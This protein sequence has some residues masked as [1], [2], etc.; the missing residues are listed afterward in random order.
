MNVRHVSRSYFDALSNGTK[1]VAA[2]CRQVPL[3]AQY[4]FGGKIPAMN[5]T[6]MNDVLQAPTWVWSRV[7]VPYRQV[8]PRGWST[9]LGFRPRSKVL[10]EILLWHLCALSRATVFSRA[11]SLGN[12]QVHD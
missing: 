4:S 10:H 5:N 12:V 11:F 8:P 3:S 7:R 2:T 1:H 6:A 9:H